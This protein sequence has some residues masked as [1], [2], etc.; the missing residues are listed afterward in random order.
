MRIL[1][2]GINYWPDEFGIAPF[3][4]GRCEYL[5]SRGH[6]VTICTG[7]PYYPRWRIPDEYRG[8]IV[9]REERNGVT[10]LRSWLYVP[11]RVTSA[12]RV[13]HEGSFIAMSL[14]RALGLR[15]P[16]VLFVVS[17]PLG[18][19][20]PARMLSRL[21]RIPY[22]FHVADMQPDAAVDL[23][24]LKH[25]KLVRLLH[26][27]ERLAYRKAALVSTLTA[28]MQERIVSKGIAPHKVVL[29][30]DW[31]DPRLFD[32]A[33]CG[34]GHEFR[35]A[36]GLRDRFI[37]VHA[38]NMGVKQGLDVVL[39]AA[40]RSR[41]VEDLIY[42]LVGDGAARAA[43]EA[44]ADAM[45]LPNL[46]LLPA[47]PTQVFNDMLAATD[48]ALI[49]QQSVVADIVFPSKTIMLLAAGRPI[50][51]SLSEGSEVARVLREAQAGTVVAPEDSDALFEGVMALRQDARARA[52][53][54]QNGREYARRSWD[55]QRILPELEA[56]LLRTAQNGRSSRG[57]AQARQDVKRQPDYLQPREQPAPVTRA[58]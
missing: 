46:K 5:A 27:L 21:W 47:Q 15:K 49:T 31:T 12:K 8:R 41:A 18:L 55:S 26:R 43:L 14:L 53:C 2:L 58:K 16:D 25:G 33:L 1:V 23:G 11:L 17:P 6:E 13:L 32:I 19:S 39:G 24:M 54:G 36:F 45:K 50:V 34:G 42:L 48:I 38:G 9:E 3:S 52:A 44:R 29:F 22:V 4:T 30:R 28:A 56:H 20:V 40:Q 37:V 7:F 35:K 57:L 10:I 51:A